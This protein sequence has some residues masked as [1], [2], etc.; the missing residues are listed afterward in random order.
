MQSLHGLLVSTLRLVDLT[1]HSHLELWPLQVAE[2]SQVL[3]VA[4]TH[5]Q[6]GVPMVQIAWE[7]NRKQTLTNLLPYMPYS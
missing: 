5:P 2:S 1:L 7:Q 3:L 6:H 4:P